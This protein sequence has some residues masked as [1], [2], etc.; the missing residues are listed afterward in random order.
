[1]DYLWCTFSKEIKYRMNTPL[2]NIKSIINIQGNLHRIIYE[3]V[4][5][6]LYKDNL[7]FIC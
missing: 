6:F 5:P 3:L 4:Y 2:Q 1:M 7:I